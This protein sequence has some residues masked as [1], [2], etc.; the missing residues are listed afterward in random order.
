MTD[1]DFWRM[2]RERIVKDGGVTLEEVEA[3]LAADEQKELQQLQ[4]LVEKKA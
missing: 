2:I 3:R 1:P 4:T